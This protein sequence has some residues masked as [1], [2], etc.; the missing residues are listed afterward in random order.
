MRFI[1]VF[2]IFVGL[3]YILFGRFEFR[4]RYQF[5]RRIATNRDNA[6]GAHFFILNARFDY[7][8][9]PIHL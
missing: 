6:F 7:S 3:R 2:I 9:A 8:L 5:R 1:C 4:Y